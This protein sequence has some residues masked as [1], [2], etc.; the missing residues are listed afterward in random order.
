MPR[1][2]DKIPNGLVPILN[3][4]Q[5]KTFVTIQVIFY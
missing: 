3:I 4:C 2:I 5:I 1:F